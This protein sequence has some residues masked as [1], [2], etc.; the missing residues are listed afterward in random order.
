M[1]LRLRFSGFERDVVTYNC[2]IDGL[3]KIYWIERARKL[4]DEMVV[5]E[6]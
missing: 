2:L 5:K 3:C 4:F 1:F 6:C